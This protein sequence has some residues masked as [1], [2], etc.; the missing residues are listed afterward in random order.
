MTEGQNNNFI[1]LAQA[2]QLCSYSQE[3][4]SLR[5]RQGKLKA[6]KMGRDWM[7]TKEWLSEYLVL[8]NPEPKSSQERGNKLI[9]LQ[10]AAKLTPYSQEYLSLRV[11]QGKLQAKKQGRNWYTTEE[12]IREYAER[13]KQFETQR[14]ALKIEAGGVQKNEIE[15]PAGLNEGATRSF[16]VLFQQVQAP[17]HPFFAS[18]IVSEGEF[19][20]FFKPVNYGSQAFLAFSR[21]KRGVAETLVELSQRIEAK[22]LNWRTAGVYWLLRL[23]AL[24]QNLRISQFEPR[25]ALADARRFR[26]AF[27]TLLLLAGGAFF[28]KVVP[29]MNLGQ[30]TQ[31]VLSQSHVLAGNAKNSFSELSQISS[32]KKLHELIGFCDNKLSD[33]S[34]AG[35]VVLNKLNESK[36]ESVKAADQ[37]VWQFKNAGQA[38][39]RGGGNVRDF[40]LSVPPRAKIFVAETFRNISIAATN[41]KNF[42]TQ[43]PR[44]ATAAGDE[45]AEYILTVAQNISEFPAGVVK[46]YSQLSQTNESAKASFRAFLNETKNQTKIF[47]ALSLSDFKNYPFVVYDK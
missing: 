30:K 8:T 25:L 22:L 38:F 39:A 33:L 32:Q 21:L 13:V 14:R 17:I 23:R 46:R 27:L 7:T 35:K 37:V 5:A 19:D 9:L 4:L 18:N 31:K 36:K 20:V 41:A 43:S 6:K 47:A 3:Y 28:A 45:L 10:E 29:N 11:R 44:L 42:M 15:N 26:A 24:D 1:S 34:V 12:W 2:S 40:V 16:Y